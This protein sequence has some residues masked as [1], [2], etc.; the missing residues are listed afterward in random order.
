METYEKDLCSRKVALKAWQIKDADEIKYTN[1][2]MTI[3]I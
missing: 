2:T 3:M 1:N